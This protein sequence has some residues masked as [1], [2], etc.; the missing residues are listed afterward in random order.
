MISEHDHL[1]ALAKVRDE[2]QRELERYASIEG[3]AHLQ[4]I[5]E[6]DAAEEALSQAYFLIK[7]QS[8]QWSNNFGHEEALEEIEDAQKCTIIY[9]T[10]VRQGV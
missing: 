3:K 2:H 8:P 10:K 1:A 6:R 9:F 5:D 7:G 4:T